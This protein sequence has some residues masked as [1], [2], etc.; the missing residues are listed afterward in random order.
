MSR[1]AAGFS[2]VEVLVALL[3]TCIGVLGMLTMQGRTIGYAQ[4]TLLR[5]REQTGVTPSFALS[6]KPDPDRL[7]YLRYGSA[8]R[9]SAPGQSRSGGGDGVE[10]DELASLEIGWKQALGAGH[11]EASAWLS[12]WSHVRSDTLT[13][14]ALIETVEAGDARIAG[15]ELSV[16]LP[17]GGGRSIEAGGN[18]TD[19]RLIRNAL[20]YALRDTRL[21]VVPDHSLRAA[22]AQVF[23]LGGMKGAARIG[24]RYVGPAHLSFDPDLDRRMGNLLESGVEASLSRGNWT[25][26]AAAANPLGRKGRAFAYGYDLRKPTAVMPLSISRNEASCDMARRRVTRAKKPISVYVGNA[27]EAAWLK[28]LGA[29]VF[30]LSSDQGFLRQAAAAGLKEVRDKVGDGRA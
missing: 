10:G 25:L 1:P 15:V 29:S 8:V 17:V 20:G 28:S 21:P 2:L 12:R 9:Q 7:V 16:D 11:V 14:S 22:L 5:E 24:L 3:V 13:P 4:D 19:A 18:V 30:V 23:A 27:T 6:W 26:S